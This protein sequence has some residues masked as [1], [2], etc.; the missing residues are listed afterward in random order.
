MLD[1][2][3]T[4]TS[5]ETACQGFESS[6]PGSSGDSSVAE[7]QSLVR[8]EYIFSGILYFAADVRVNGYFNCVN[9]RY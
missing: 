9:Q 7:R 5:T 4:V 6:S 3:D 2:A 8:V 1:A